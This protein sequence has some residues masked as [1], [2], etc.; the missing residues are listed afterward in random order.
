[1]A[2]DCNKYVDAK[3][4]SEGEH[5]PSLWRDWTV[6]QPQGRNHGRFMR[7][8]KCDEISLSQ[9]RRKDLDWDPA[10][11]CVLPYNDEPEFME[12]E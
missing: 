1:M 10:R 6:I 7:L 12:A 4:E 11:A 3:H 8:P 5:K 9:N 2:I